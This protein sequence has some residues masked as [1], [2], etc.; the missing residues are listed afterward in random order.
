MLQ[1]NKYPTTY[2]LTQAMTYDGKAFRAFFESEIPA[3]SEITVS[4][5]NGE[6]IINLFYRRFFSNMPDVRYE[7][8]TGAVITAYGAEIPILPMNAVNV[9]QSTNTARLCTTSSIGTLQDI[10]I[11]GGSIGVGN[12]PAGGTL[13]DQD[14]LKVLPPNT[15]FLIR[16]ANPNTDPAKALVYLK[17]F[18][19]HQ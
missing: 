3:E 14:D 7:V 11:S 8:R 15:E 19:T 5:L 13:D 6:N 18:E 12:R 1:P 4:I 10:E 16:L 9:R 17:W 2:S